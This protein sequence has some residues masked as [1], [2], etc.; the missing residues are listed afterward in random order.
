[1]EV[2]QYCSQLSQE[3][4]GHKIRVR[5]FFSKFFKTKLSYT[6]P[7]VFFQ[8]ETVSHIHRLSFNRDD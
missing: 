4:Q 5:P 1:M 7:D 2:D 3:D 8:P 6:N